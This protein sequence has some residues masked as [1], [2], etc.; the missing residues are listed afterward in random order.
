MPLFSSSSIVLPTYW[1]LHL[2]ISLTNSLLILSSYNPLGK[3]SATDSSTAALCSYSNH[4]QGSYL[5]SKGLVKVFSKSIHTKHQLQKV[6]YELLQPDGETAM[7]K[8][9]RGLHWERLTRRAAWKRWWKD[10]CRGNCK[11]LE[12]KG[13]VCTNPKGWER[14]WGSGGGGSKGFV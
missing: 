2:S 13:R 12:V 11:N 4:P 10:S 7:L 3:N 5:Q 1:S 8:R 9:L 14:S 6:Q